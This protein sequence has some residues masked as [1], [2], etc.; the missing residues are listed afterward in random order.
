MFVVGEVMN[1]VDYPVF[2]V[3][4]I[5]AFYDSNGNL[6]GANEV[7]TMLPRIESG[8][9]SPFKLKGGEAS[10]VDRYE[11][12]I[13]WDDFTVV[14]YEEMTVLTQDYS[15]EEGF[16]VFGDIRNDGSTAVNDV[17]VVVTFYD[18]SGEVIDNVVGVAEEVQLDPGQRTSYTIEIPTAVDFQSFVVQSQARLA[19]Y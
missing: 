17:R 19:L 7:E 4:I 6:V 3:R 9:P 2:G 1:G 12:T 15:D 11:L 18:A 10:N 5:A 14:N 16:E 13:A 8:L